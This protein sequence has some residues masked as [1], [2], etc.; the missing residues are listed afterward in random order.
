MASKPVL[1]GYARVSTVDQNL[2]LQR[3]TLTEAGCGE[4]Y[5]EQMSGAVA[6]RPALHDA[7]EFVRSGD[8]L[9]V[10]KLSNLELL[11]WSEATIRIAQR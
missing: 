4:I 1:V 3:D 11:H 5:T 8:T 9:I 2:A 7:L 10:W 6:D